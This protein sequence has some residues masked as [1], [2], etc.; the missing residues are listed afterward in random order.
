M[1]LHLELPSSPGRKLRFLPLGMK[2][3]HTDAVYKA[4]TKPDFLSG[5]NTPTSS[6]GW[7][8]RADP[9]MSQLAARRV[10]TQGRML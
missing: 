4:G 1:P 3:G 7:A 2:T 10:S 8:R 6:L 5:G 9:Y